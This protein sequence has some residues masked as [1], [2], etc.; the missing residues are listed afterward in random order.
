MVPSMSGKGDCWDNAVAES[1]FA[2][3][4]REL[5]HKCTW[6]S[7]KA[8][9]IAIHDYIEVF[10]NRVRKHSSNGYMSPIDF[11]RGFKNQAAVAA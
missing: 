7:L 9:R 1:F 5:V 8:T 11:E 3:L 10:Y 6:Q 2:T 4:K